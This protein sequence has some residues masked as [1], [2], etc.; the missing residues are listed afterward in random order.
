MQRIFHNDQLVG[1]EHTNQL[2]MR[3]Q[4]LWLVFFRRM[5]V[6]A[7][8]DEA[9]TGGDSE[10]AQKCGRVAEILPFGIH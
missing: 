8:S 7:H 10:N 1:A 4:R 3:L 5:S 2:R 9:R 6:K